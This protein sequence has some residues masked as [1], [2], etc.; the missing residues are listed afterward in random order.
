MECGTGM[1]KEWWKKKNDKERK[2][3]NDVQKL[4]VR[5]N[6]NNKEIQKGIEEW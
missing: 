1:V 3:V 2:K 4:K 6:K 5:M